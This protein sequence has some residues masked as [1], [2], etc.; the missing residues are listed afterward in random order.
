MLG[1]MNSDGTND[2]DSLFD[3]YRNDSKARNGAG[4]GAS[5]RKHSL[6][7]RR[8]EEDLDGSAWIHRDKLAKIESREL[9]QAGFRVGRRRQGTRSTSRSTSRHRKAGEP[10]VDEAQSDD[11][12]PI[13][14]DERRRLPSP[15]LA[16]E[17]P[18]DEQAPLDHELRTPEEVAADQ[19]KMPDRNGQPLRPGTSRI[20]LPKYSPAPV[21][22]S[23]IERDS[24]LTRSRNNSGAWGNTLEDGI[25]FSKSRERSQSIGSQALLD[26][27]D[28]TSEMPNSPTQSSPSKAKVPSKATPTSGARKNATTGPRTASTPQKKTTR[29]GSTPLRESPSKRPASS[30]GMLSR[31]T[32]SHKPP[33]GE[34][35]WIATMYKPDPRLPPEE[36]MLPTH[37]KRMMQEQWE[38]EG[39]IGYVYDRDFRLVGPH[40]F[41]EPKSP[42]VKSSSEQ[43][44]QP[45]D[46]VN[47]KAES[48][49]RAP[50]ESWPL[51]PDRLDTNLHQHRPST[52][53]EHGGY[54]LTPTVQSPQVS[55]H[56]QQKPANMAPIPAT[57]PPD[58]IRIP[59]PPEEP[60]KKKKGGCACCIVM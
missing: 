53:G 22:A 29:S 8:E 56:L 43:Q 25:V 60:E 5:S 27:T 58:P 15:I 16:E 2:G 47:E 57:R 48:R 46:D 19:T 35:P 51:A 36:Q 20:P 34:A 37:A 54:S 7:E 4:S 31:P 12:S 49:Q 32:T 21:P 33:E 41:P 17:E 42:P 50:N 11:I 18:Q 44:R 14:R 24:P 39:K 40:E 6:G 45:Q 10:H 23:F 26:D 38:K 9:E 28:Q 3:L 30:G 55:P 13:S 52:S 1:R 59:E